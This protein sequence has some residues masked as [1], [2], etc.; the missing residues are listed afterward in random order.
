MDQKNPNHVNCLLSYNQNHSDLLNHQE[1]RRSTTKSC[2][3]R[4]RQ[5]GS[6]PKTLEDGS[7]QNKNYR[8]LVDFQPNELFIL[9]KPTVDLA[10]YSM[11]TEVSLLKCIFLIDIES[12]LQAFTKWSYWTIINLIGP[13]PYHRC[14]YLVWTNCKRF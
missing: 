2:I 4:W 6:L 13:S 5:A 14:L 7:Q 9:R 1:I 11:V 3:K 12:E 8:M 10:W